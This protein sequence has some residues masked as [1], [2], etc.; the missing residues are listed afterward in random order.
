MPKFSKIKWRDKDKELLKKTVKNFNAK[1]NRLLKKN[2]YA[3]SY[4]PEKVSYSKLKQDLQYRKDF[5]KMI[6]SLQRFSRK[7][8]EELT[9]FIDTPMTRWEKREAAISKGNLNRMRTAKRKKLEPTPEKGNM[10]SIEEMGLGYKQYPSGK[11]ANW[12][13]FVDQLHYLGSTK[14]EATRAQRYLENYCKAADNNLYEYADIV[15][16]LAKRMGGIPLYYA[17]A[18]NEFL[19]IDYEYPQGVS[20]AHQ[21]QRI[22]DAFSDYGIELTSSEK[23]QYKD[24]L[25]RAEYASAT[26]NLE[27]SD[28]NRKFGIP[29]D[30]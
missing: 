23:N 19:Q 30:D 14:Y 24:L 12:K 8:A 29:D 21:A 17:Y 1:I 7:G 20:V 25:T 22:I 11:Y 9:S 5:N 3:E 13:K 6:K 18:D 28:Y 27:M 4:L 2:P 15:K 26:H 10:S 16:I